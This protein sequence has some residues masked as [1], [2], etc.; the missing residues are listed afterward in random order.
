MGKNKG[1]GRKTSRIVRT[2][3]TRFGHLRKRLQ[4]V[5]ERP[6]MKVKNK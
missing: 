5:A 1:H 2:P 4:K 6:P 3:A